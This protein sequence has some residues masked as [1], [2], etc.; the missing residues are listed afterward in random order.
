MDTVRRALA[1]GLF[2]NAAQGTG[3]TSRWTMLSTIFHIHK[4]APAQEDVLTFLT[5]QEVITLYVA[6]PAEQ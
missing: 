3:T 6:K 5:G 2:M 1:R 4:K